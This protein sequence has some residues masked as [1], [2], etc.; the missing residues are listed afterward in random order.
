VGRI[1]TRTRPNDQ[2]FGEQGLEALRDLIPVL[3]LAVKSGTQAVIAR[4]LGRVYLGRDTCEQVLRGKIS[5]GV[6]ERINTVLWFSDLRGSTQIYGGLICIG[7]HSRLRI[8]SCWSA[9]LFWSRSPFGY[10]TRV[11]GGG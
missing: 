2:G 6:T 10:R 4:T 8:Y 7:F 5:R 3:G 1:T 9:Q 11:G